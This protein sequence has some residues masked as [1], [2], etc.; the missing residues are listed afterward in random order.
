VDVVPTI[1]DA[2][3]LDPALLPL[4]RG[5]SPAARRGA[6]VSELDWTFRGVRRRPG[7]PAGQHHAWMLRTERWNKQV[8][9]TGG[10]SPQLF[11][12]AANPEEFFDLGAEPSLAP[13]RK[14]LR[15]R[16]L[17]WFT[18][19]RCRTTLTWTEADLRT[20]AP[21]RRACS[22]RAV[23]RGASRRCAA[24]TNQPLSGR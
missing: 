10:Y 8:H 21:T 24:A 5:A 2:L 18:G 16:Q 20:D 4:A 3:A 11:D 17:A 23:G 22:S 14:A 13:V 12:L 7:R 9:G 1:L 15:E 6:V 19:L